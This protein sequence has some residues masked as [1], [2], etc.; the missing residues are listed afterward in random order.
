MKRYSQ[1]SVKGQVVIPSE[2]RDELGLETG[3]RVS[4]ERQGDALLMR[5]ITKAYV[6]SLRGCLKGPSLADIR[7]REHRDDREI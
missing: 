4:F 6:A 1:L 5:P 7:D 3:T 2:F